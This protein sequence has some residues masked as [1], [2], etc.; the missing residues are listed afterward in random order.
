[1]C[2]V[3][4]KPLVEIRVA[5]DRLGDF[6]EPLKIVSRRRLLDEAGQSDRG[7]VA[8]GHLIG[9]GV[10]DD[11]GAQVAL[12]NDVNRLCKIEPPHA[13]NF[14]WRGTTPLFRQ[15]LKPANVFVVGE[16]R[17]TLNVPQVQANILWSSELLQWM[18]PRFC[19][20]DFR[21]AWS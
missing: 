13:L 20:L 16:K 8:N 10:L 9:R 7:Q 2:P 6:V 17:V 21:F 4:T 14:P 12:G 5:P 15:V 11:L 19:W 1:M 18:V 3:S